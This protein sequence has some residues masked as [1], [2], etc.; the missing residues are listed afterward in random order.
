MNV[1]TF[2]AST[3]HY[4]MEMIREAMGDNAVILST[5]PLD[6]G[7][8][9]EV[10]AAYD[11]PEEPLPSTSLYVKAPEPA[12]D[13]VKDVPPHLSIFMPTM[14][15]ILRHHGVN[16]ETVNYLTKSASRLTLHHANYY[17]HY[18]DDTEQW[19]TALMA[20][21]FAMSPCNLHHDSVRYILI[22]PP[23]AGKTL[24]AA[25]IAAYCVKYNRPVHVI[26]T[27]HKRAGAIE[28]LAAIT[29]ILGLELLVAD[30]RA[31]LQAILAGISPTDTVIVDSAGANPYDFQELKRLAH[32]A[33]LPQLEPVLVYPAGSDPMEADEIAR[34][35]SFLGAQRMIITRIDAARRFGGILNAACAANL[36]LAH[37][38]GS[39]RIMGTFTPCTPEYL[40]KLCMDF[41]PASMPLYAT[42]SMSDHHAA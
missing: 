32:Y 42:E 28:Q 41:Q 36:A 7:N 40:M 38:T 33:S 27:D 5:R 35:F 22:G 25:K 3:I 1:Q 18:Q 9:V 34:A 37:C 26:T 10:V 11:I 12:E 29:N 24:T 14:Q 16:D 13:F 2:T 6:T 15:A 20:E 19:M 30:N 4:A 17:R 23:G 39:E 31:A 8:G 21:A